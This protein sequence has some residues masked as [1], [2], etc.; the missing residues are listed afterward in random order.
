MTSSPAFMRASSWRPAPGPGSS[1]RPPAKR[2]LLTRLPGTVRQQAHDIEKPLQPC[3][4]PILRG[5]GATVEAFPGGEIPLV[6]DREKAVAARRDS[7]LFMASVTGAGM[8]AEHGDPSVFRWIIGS[9][10]PLHG[11]A[12][13]HGA[14]LLVV[15]CCGPRELLGRRADSPANLA[16]SIT[17]RIA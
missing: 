11:T 5:V 9:V 14:K 7:A 15:V 4:R 17:A 6:A 8:L 2:S 3:C 10:G 13:C 12:S 1:G 16:Q